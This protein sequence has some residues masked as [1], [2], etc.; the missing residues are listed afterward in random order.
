MGKRMSKR[1][2]K[3]EKWRRNRQLKRMRQLSR[4]KRHH[5]SLPKEKIVK[6]CGLP[7]I[8]IA[9]ERFSLINNTNET[10]DFFSNVY[11]MIHK[12]EKNAHLFFNLS[13]VKYV[14]T[15]TI[16]YFIAIINN[17]KRLRALSIKCSG[18]MPYEFRTRQ[19]FEKV[20]FYDYV[21][22]AKFVTETKD[23]NRIKI[24]QG[25]EINGE[26]ASTICDFV[27]LKTNSDS[28]IATKRLYPMLIE[29]MAN[30]K[31]HAYRD[32]NGKMLPKWYI[33]VENCENEIK[34]VFLDTGAGIPN[35]IRRNWVERIRDLFGGDR[36]DATYIEA[37]LKG[38][39]RTETKQE[40]RGKGL[41]EIYSAVISEGSRMEELTIISGH[42]LCKVN[43][44]KA[45]CKEYIDNSF[46][47][48]MFIW[49]FRKE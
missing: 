32:E 41:P 13:N 20:G 45:I 17:L 31:Q 28:I 9:P 49:N 22:M 30:V 8:I 10:V 39:F 1:E 34:F 29:L 48:S 46:D 16:M 14:T 42:G 19:L 4:H 25:T 38:E 12:C 5:Y 43:Y 47:G 35:T 21:R 11:D 27:N 3:R 6:K 23:P 15:D 37:S 26:T 18:N 24:I 36:D 7:H 2:K 44:R 33:Y 40:Y